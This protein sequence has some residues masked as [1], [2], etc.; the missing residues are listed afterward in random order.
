MSKITVITKNQIFSVVSFILAIIFLSALVYVSNDNADIKVKSYNDFRKY[1]EEGKSFDFVFDV[2]KEPN[3]KIMDGVLQYSST[4]NNLFIKQD[5]IVS[6]A[7]KLDDKGR[8]KIVTR[9]FLP[10][11]DVNFDVK[12]YDNN[13]LI[14]HLDRHGKLNRSVFLETLTSMVKV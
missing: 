11:G 8:K 7:Q 5:S 2:T 4:L 14:Q 1:A 12:V 3:E 10:N 13:K 6:I 9:T